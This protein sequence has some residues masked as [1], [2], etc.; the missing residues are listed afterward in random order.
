MSCAKLGQA[1]VRWW[2]RQG[3]YAV[4]VELHIRFGP[5]TPGMP[6]VCAQ[7]VGLSSG[8]IGVLYDE[9]CKGRGG[10]GCA[11]A[12]SVGSVTHMVLFW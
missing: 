2:H 10:M 6:N 4:S 12:I 5:E 8:M 9:A 3:N 11:T 7:V 1:L